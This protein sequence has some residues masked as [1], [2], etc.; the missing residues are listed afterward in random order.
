MLWAMSC[1]MICLPSHA[2]HPVRSGYTCSLVVI[3][4]AHQHKCFR[5]GYSC[6]C[7][8]AN[9]IH[10][11]LLAEVQANCRPMNVSIPLWAMFFVVTLVA[12][13]VTN[14]FKFCVL[15]CILEWTSELVLC[16]CS[17]TDIL[18][19]LCK[20]LKPCSVMTWDLNIVWGNMV[21]RH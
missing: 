5:G 10:Q 15:W 20:G 2:F 9:G 18:A 16:Y 1:C 7:C 6:V 4:M 8:H 12:W 3:A 21:N 14:T 17:A 11:C 19:P 13:S